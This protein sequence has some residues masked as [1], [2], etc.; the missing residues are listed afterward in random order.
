[1]NIFEKYESEV[2]SYCRSFPT[3]FTKAKNDI[4]VDR[5]GDQYIDF[6]AGAGTLNY[7]HNSPEIIAELVNYMN[8]NGVIHGLDMM[9]DAK[10]KFLRS[11]AS[12]ILEPRGLNYKIQFPGPTGTNA[13]E[14]ALKLARKVT[15]RKNVISFTNAFHGM[16]QASLA[17][18]GNKFK[19]AGA[20]MELS[21]SYF[22]PYDGYHGDNIDTVQ[23]IAKYLEDNGSGYDLPAAVIVETVQGEGGVNLASKKWLKSLEEL[24]H[25][26]KILLIVDDI[27]MGCGRTGT[28]FSF[29]EMGITPDIVCLSKSLSGI[30]LPM[31]LTL[32]KPEHDIWAPGEHNGTFRGHNLAFVA[33]TKTL[34][35]WSDQKFISGLDE[36]SEIIRS[37]CAYIEKNH[38]GKLRTRGRGLIC[39]LEFMNQEAA[40]KLSKFAFD[41]KL[42]IETSGINDQVLKIIPALTITND[43]LSKGLKIIEHGIKEI[44]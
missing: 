41:N 38:P 6:F 21:G 32:F 25:K 35:S 22:M 40:G 13:V 16:T 27:Q 43:N 8:E 2:R 42:I 7:G 12:H 37:W 30:G 39:G 5:A 11:F 28:F 18:T 31:S 10:E 44:A 1:M 26:Y 29:E 24:C 33:A 34:E 20:G 23:M 9:T 36:K 17:V 19:R 15:G 14:T 3:V 4:L